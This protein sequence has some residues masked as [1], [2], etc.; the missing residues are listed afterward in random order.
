VTSV[1]IPKFT[2]ACGTL[3]CELRNQRDTSNS[4]VLAPLLSPKFAFGLWARVCELR[5][6]GASGERSPP[7]HR[8]R[9]RPGTLATMN[10][11]TSVQHSRSL[12]RPAVR[13]ERAR[14]GEASPH[15]LNR[16]AL[17]RSN[18]SPSRR[19]RTGVGCY[20]RCD[21]AV[22]RQHA[23]ISVQSP[24]KS[25]GNDRLRNV[26]VDGGLSGVNRTRFAHC[27]TLSG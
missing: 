14:I 10:A 17:G 6:R 8:R 25:V 20:Q 27:A 22:G 7:S 1:R 19:C 5:V 23:N 11:T 16:F 3:S 9:A 24:H 2:N 26:C 18:S 12:A 21:R 4:M 13:L 15:A